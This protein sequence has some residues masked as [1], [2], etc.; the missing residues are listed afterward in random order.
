MMRYQRGGTVNVYVALLLLILSIGEAA[1]IRYL[2]A[3]RAIQITM[4][5]S[6]RRSIGVVPKHAYNCEYAGVVCY[7]KI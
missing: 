4:P 1:A 2:L 7:L 6:P 3:H 5:A